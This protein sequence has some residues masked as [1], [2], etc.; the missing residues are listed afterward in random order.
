MNAAAE[1]PQQQK[2]AASIFDDML[3]A[4]VR[5]QAEQAKADKIMGQTYGPGMGITAELAALKI[6]YGRDYGFGPAQSLKF[7]H[8]INGT[9]ALESSGR[10]NLLKKANYDWR[11]V[12]EK[13]FSDTEC[14]MHFFR[15]GQQ[16]TN[17]DGTPL[18]VSFSMEDANRA[19]YVENSRGSDKSK[20]GNYDKVP[21]NMLFARCLANF[22]RFFASEV[23][24][25]SMADP[26]EITMERVVTATEE[27]IAAKT[28]DAVD[29]LAERLQAEKVEIP[30]EVAK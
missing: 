22:H 13:S 16:L 27:R 12:D 28:G 5:R 9:P 24:G 1:Q 8:I 15:N 30:V 2:Q 18:V 26:N 23:D 3:D 14:R 21:K 10:T 7:I 19:G 4:T 25:S 6:A 29:A 11:P 20:K 17:S